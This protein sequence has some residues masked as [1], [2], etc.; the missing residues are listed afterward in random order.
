MTPSLTERLIV[1]RESLGNQESKA[2]IGDVLDELSAWPWR[3]SVLVE[4]LKVLRSSRELSPATCAGSA[5]PSQPSSHGDA[6]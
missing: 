5:S 3:A 2:L 6:S 1:Y 4:E